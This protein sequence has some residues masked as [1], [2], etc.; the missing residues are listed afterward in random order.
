MKEKDI[1]LIEQCC[2]CVRLYP[3]DMD[4][5]LKFIVSICKLNKID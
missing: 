5:Y 1:E 4:K 2:D 3:E